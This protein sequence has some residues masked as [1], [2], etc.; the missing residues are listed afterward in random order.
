M[1]KPL[2]TLTLLAL[3][4]SLTLGSIARAD[5]VTVSDSGV[6]SVAVGAAGLDLSSP[7]GA[8]ILL[9]RLHHA[10][11]IACGDLVSGSRDLEA[12]SD[13]RV[14]IQGALDDAVGALNA[15]Q[16]TAL[17]RGRAVSQRVVTA[18]RPDDEPVHGLTTEFSPPS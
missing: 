17:Y 13:Y 3:A 1:T 18:W 15:P 11:S 6:T 14:C 5:T 16:V 4:V 9:A 12:W 2:T 7:A 10:A 8:N